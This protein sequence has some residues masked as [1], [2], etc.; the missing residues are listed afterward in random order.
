MNF[1]KKLTLSLL[2]LTTALLISLWL[3][4]KAMSTDNIRTYVSSQLSVMTHKKTVIKGDIGWQLLPQPGIKISKLEIGDGTQPDFNAKLDNLILNLR[5]TPLL[6]GA[7][8]FS[9]FKVD[10]FSADIYSQPSLTT[11]PKPSKSTDSV[12]APVLENH[13][14][15][16][17]FLLSKGLVRIHN[18]DNV[19]TFS[20]IQIGTEELNFQD[21][22]IPIQFKSAMSLINSG[23][24]KTKAQIQF[25]GKTRFSP[26]FLSDPL[27]NWQ[28]LAIDGQ[29]QLQDI[30]MGKLAINRIQGGASLKRKRFNI[31]PL[32]ISLYKGESVGDLDYN[33]ENRQ[34][35][36]NQTAAGLDSQKLLDDL[37]GKQLIRGKLDF[38]LH[39]EGDFRDVKYT[40][41]EGSIMIKD[42]RIDTVNL[43]QVIDEVSK[44]VDQLFSMPADDLKKMLDFREFADLARNKGHTRFKLLSMQYKLSD[45]DLHTNSVVLQTD[46]LQ[47]KGNGKL[48][49]SDYSLSA[50]LLTTVLAGNGKLEEVQQM[51]GGNFPLLVHGTLTQPQVI[52]DLKKINAKLGKFWLIN[53]VAQPVKK[54]KA[55][56]ISIFKH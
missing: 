16:N 1:L 47:L 31:S 13:F 2:G 34:L 18:Q 37:L 5:I 32:T 49:L 21:L 54:L 17:R 7:L 6:R 55:Q 4:G 36:L 12:S 50:E 15:I 9:E 44:K 19:L 28:S 46:K 52:P 11:L 10:G 23:N 33:F 38:S 48:N 29:L 8:V 43:N 25:R 35:K 27:S 51:L 42:G 20:N 39:A 41:A 22:S 30:L 14:A 24:S 53:S 40:Q 56:F 26:L 45:N 3:L